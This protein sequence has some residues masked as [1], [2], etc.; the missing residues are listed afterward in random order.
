MCVT[1]FSHLPRPITDC[2][3]SL[4]VVVVNFSRDMVIVI[5]LNNKKEKVRER[6]ISKRE[7]FQ[8]KKTSFGR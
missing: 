8:R 4:L 1:V 3:L 7:R 6:K 2:I 5:P